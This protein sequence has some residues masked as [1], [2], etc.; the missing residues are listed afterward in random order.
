MISLQNAARCSAVIV[1]D[2]TAIKSVQKLI[3]TDLASET[4][5]TLWVVGGDDRVAE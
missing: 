2:M 5:H 3:E 4:Q 1:H